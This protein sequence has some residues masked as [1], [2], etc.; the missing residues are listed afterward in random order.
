[1]AQF[2]GDSNLLDSVQVFAHKIVEIHR[3]RNEL[4]W[5]YEQQSRKSTQVLNKLTSFIKTSSSKD[6]AKYPII[7]DL[8]SHMEACKG[9][10]IDVLKQIRDLKVK[11]SAIESSE[12]AKRLEAL[13][14][15]Q[16]TLPKSL[17]T[18]IKK[19]FEEAEAAIQDFIFDIFLLIDYFPRARQALQRSKSCEPCGSNESPGESQVY[20]HWTDS[21]S[22]QDCSIC[23]DS[24]SSPSS[25]FKQKCGHSFHYE[26]IARWLN[27]KM[28][29][30]MCRQV[31]PHPSFRTATSLASSPSSDN[32]ST[33]IS[34]LAP[35]LDI[36]SL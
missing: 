11:L 27:D 15:A 28:S 33:N 2:D 19:S 34:Q 4:V 17:I 32:E 30:P 31:I 25:D 9:K 22:A 29:C 5:V 26:C 12:E 23:L 24:I 13:D 3:K 10:C 16:V 8:L 36:Q 20:Y 1:M 6:I 21:N 35:S 14:L 7:L 18:N